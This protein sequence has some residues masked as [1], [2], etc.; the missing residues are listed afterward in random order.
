MM[1]VYYTRR[2]LRCT[3]INTV[4]AVI[5]LAQKKC[6][7]KTCILFAFFLRCAITAAHPLLQIFQRNAI[8]E[9][10]FQFH[11]MFAAQP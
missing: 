1:S 10:I 3:K 8:E 5:V 2:R 4:R 11:F 9:N 7:Q 6:Q